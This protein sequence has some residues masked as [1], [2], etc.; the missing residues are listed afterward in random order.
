MQDHR[1]HSYTIYVAVSITVPPS[2]DN[3]IVTRVQKYHRQSFCSTAKMK[4][5][6]F[7]IALG[8]S[9]ANAQ[10]A[11]N[12]LASAIPSCGVSELTH[13][14]K[15]SFWY[16]PS[17]N[18]LYPP[19]RASAVHQQITPVFALPPSKHPPFSTQLN[20]ASSALVVRQQF[21][22]SQELKQSV[23]VFPQPQE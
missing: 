8:V 9:F 15:A 14:S 19:V 4:Y 16:S 13:I 22:F 20:P 18:V 23:P 11:C 2:K 3:L 10:G 6:T 17:F 1:L 7:I 5:L 12:S 21:K